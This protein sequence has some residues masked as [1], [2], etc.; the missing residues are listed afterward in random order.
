MLTVELALAEASEGTRAASGGT[1]VSP[2]SGGAAPGA[3]TGET[4]VPP[5]G[6]APRPA[7]PV[8]PAPAPAP[9]ERVRP[10]A[11]A[12]PIEG[13]LTLEVVQERWR[14]ILQEQLKR[15]RHSATSAIVLEGFPVGLNG[16]EIHLVFPVTHEFHYRNA[17]G[18]HKP[19][20]EEALGAILGQ[21]VTIVC[22]QGD[23]GR[24]ETCA[25]RK[26]EVESGGETAAS[27]PV[28]AEGEVVTSVVVEAPGPDS[29]PANDA[30]DSAGPSGSETPVG[31]A[32]QS[33]AVEAPGPD[34]SPSPGD[35]N[36]AGPSGDA[37]PAARPHEDAV[38]DAV[39]RTLELFE[40]SQELPER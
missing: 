20:I 32:A 30:G 8:A 19:V 24:T 12:V 35:G 14:N 37:P 27:A 16:S 1:G 28:Q 9:A 17:C 5:R 3:D 22:T 26:S 36:S 10:V 40:G 2:V 33:A 4:P 15:M 31:E 34:S 7:A 11:T 13:E 23:V 38:N 25:S 21:P 18:K 29:S 6:E 39:A